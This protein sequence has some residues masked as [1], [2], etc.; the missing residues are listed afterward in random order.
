MVKFTD[1]M[2][3]EIVFPQ[4]DFKIV[5]VTGNESFLNETEKIFHEEIEIKYFYEG[6]SVLMVG[7]EVIVT[8]P[9]DI[10]I[11]NPYEFHTTIDVGR[12][13]GKYHLINL[14]L[15]F[16][17]IDNSNGLDLRR[18]L[19]G[20]GICFPNLIRE[21]YYLQQ[22]IYRIVEEMQKKEASYKLMVRCIMTEFFVIATRISKQGEGISP[23]MERN[24]YYYR[25]IEPV[26]Q[27]I[28]SFYNQKI[29][30][31]T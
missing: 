9:G 18:L 23:V 30:L 5:L 12:N 1:D 25:I 3:K 21:N 15:D 6:S 13:K 22:L 17:K 20:K 2:N 7:T 16:L 8:Q 10:V 29:T 26:L 27:Y 4:S 28:Y 11:I 14:S 24:L 31:E 19:F